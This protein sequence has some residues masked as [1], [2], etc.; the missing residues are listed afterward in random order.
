MSDDDL[1]RQVQAFIR[2]TTD[3]VR[4]TTAEAR[5]LRT[6][7]QRFL[8]RMLSN[9]PQSQ[10]AFA[11]LRDDTLDILRREA[12]RDALE[13]ATQKAAEAALFQAESILAE[14]EAWLPVTND[15]KPKRPN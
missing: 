3:Y 1:R 4:V 5:A 13:P 6:I 14:L 11:Q 7:L 9:H 2:E 8:W 12:A 10:A 15:A